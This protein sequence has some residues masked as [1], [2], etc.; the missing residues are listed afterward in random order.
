MLSFGLQNVLNKVGRNNKE[1]IEATG[2]RLI[3][4]MRTYQAL[5]CINIVK[6]REVRVQLK[7]RKITKFNSYLLTTVYRYVQIIHLT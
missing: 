6:L 1:K 7:N 5:H 3:L 2:G 4:E